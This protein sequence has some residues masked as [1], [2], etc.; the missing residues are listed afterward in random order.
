LIPVHED[1]LIPLVPAAPGS[2]RHHAAPYINTVITQQK[3]NTSALKR[4]ENKRKVKSPSK[5]V[6]KKRLPTPSSTVCM[7][8][9]KKRTQLMEHLCGGDLNW[10]IR[11]LA[12]PAMRMGAMA[13]TALMY[14][15]GLSYASY[16]LLTY[17]T[18]GPYVA[19]WR[20]VESNIKHMSP[21]DI[22][23]F[24][25]TTTDGKIQSYGFIAND[26]VPS[27]MVP[28]LQAY[29]AKNGIARK[30]EARISLDNFQVINMIRKCACV[31]SLIAVITNHASCNTVRRYL[32]STAAIKTM[33]KFH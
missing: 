30:L 14:D 1:E 7:K 12:L 18:L 21:K 19:P 6:K 25:M 28:E 4:K 5:G 23:T 15:L 8:T 3:R 9:F 17:S 22:T 16:R 33:S 11:K 27:R 29:L 20:V 10:H 31:G 26:F 2:T 32:T 13:S 24:D